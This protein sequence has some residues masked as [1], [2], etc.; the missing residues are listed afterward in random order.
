MHSIH[1][2]SLWVGCVQ[3]VD[4]QWFIG[5]QDRELSH[6]PQTER[7][8]VGIS[9]QVIHAFSQVVHTLCAQLKAL[10]KSVSAELSTLSTG[11]TTRTTKYKKGIK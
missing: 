3:R 7:K 1:Y 10:I 4:T 8:T 11:L 5:A 2:A 6:Y 9:S